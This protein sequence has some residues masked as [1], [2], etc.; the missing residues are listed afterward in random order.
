MS[1]SAGVIV[2]RDVTKTYKNGSLEVQAL[3]GV[4]FT[5]A[6]GEIVLFDKAYVDFAHLY[7]LLQRVDSSVEQR[8][9]KSIRSIRGATAAGCP[10]PLGAMGR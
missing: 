2:C 5:I 1:D 10:G 9:P 8:Q 7:D 4:S 6:A 3:R